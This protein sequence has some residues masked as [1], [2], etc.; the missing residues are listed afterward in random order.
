MES[1]KSGA[2]PNHIDAAALAALFAAFGR[3]RRLC[4]RPPVEEPLD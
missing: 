4:F 1:A 2:T 3:R